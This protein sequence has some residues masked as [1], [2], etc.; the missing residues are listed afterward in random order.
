MAFS[1]KHFLSAEQDWV[2]WILFYRSAPQIC[3]LDCN[4]KH[5]MFI[6]KSGYLQ[7]LKT[8]RTINLLNFKNNQQRLMVCQEVNTCQIDIETKYHYF[9]RNKVAVWIFFLIKL[10]KYENG[11]YM[12]VMVCLLIEGYH[13]RDL[14]LCRAFSV[15]YCLIRYFCKNCTRKC[16]RTSL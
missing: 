2:S 7:S 9:P 14:H 8:K 5:T 1:L 16:Q 11:S 4:T 10:L 13:P 12:K 3:T 15:F 6:S